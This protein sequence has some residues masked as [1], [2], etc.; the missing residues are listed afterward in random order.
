MPVVRNIS[1]HAAHDP[2]LALD[3]RLDG[4]SKGSGKW[5]DL[6]VYNNHGTLLGMEAA[7]LV[8]GPGGSGFALD[9]DG[10][11]AEY[12]SVS[13]DPALDATTSGISFCAWVSFDGIG[14]TSDAVLSK[15]RAAVNFNYHLSIDTSSRA[16]ADLYDGTNNPY[17]RYNTSLSTG[18]WYHLVGTYDGGSSL[19]IYVNG[20]QRGSGNSSAF[21]P[22]A[23]DAPLFIARWHD[24]NGYNLDGRVTG[25]RV[26]QRV[27]S[28]SEIKHLYEHGCLPIED[29]RIR[30]RRKRK[31]G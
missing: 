14:A 26:Y 22:S 11:D 6:S 31:A 30:R 25:A 7:D 9:F 5:P 1:N 20:I 27:L 19:L 21:V 10:S 15:G 3:L 18:T 24:Y 2:D 28:A 29:A 8:I 13:Y 4:A 12:V 23:E 17:A 16:R